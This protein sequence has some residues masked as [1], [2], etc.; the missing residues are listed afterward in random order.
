MYF[1]TFT[2]FLQMGKHGFYVWIAYGT[3]LVV[4]LGSWL[5]ARAAFSNVTKQLRQRAELAQRAGADESL[6]GSHNESKT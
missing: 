1:D 2:E 4:V 3:T 6:I 5:S